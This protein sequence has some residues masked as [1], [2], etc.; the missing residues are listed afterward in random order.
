M[1]RALIGVI[2]GSGLYD[3][4]GL[5]EV[6]EV[7]IDTP[8]GRTSDAI[9][10]GKLAGVPVA[11]LARH[12]RN[13]HLIPSQVPYRANIHA[14]RQLGVRYILSLSAVGSLQEEVRPLDMLIPD[15]FIDMTRRRQSTFFGDG[16]V[17]H[18]SM[19]DPVCPAVADSLARAFT[20]TQAE[21]P[22][23][24]HR[25]GSYICIEGPQFSTRAESHWYRSMGASVIGMTNMPEAKLAREAQ[26]AYATLA[27]ATDYDCWHP[28]EEAVTAEVAIANLQQNATRAQQIA[29]EAIRI[30]GAEQP[31]SSAHTALLS[32]LVT[33]L[34]A[35]PE[36]TQAVIKPLLAPTEP[37]LEEM[38]Q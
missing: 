23:E 37:E 8:F 14:L 35:M 9:V 4:P 32:G 36:E 28:R 1:T 29:M 25:G 34:E 38:E 19:A 13:H 24:L 18:V 11:F 10:C 30:L 21:Q 17:A 15:Q 33:P 5:T 2:G 20:L 16:A 27:M 31:E 12:G 3:M 7:H 26:I 6:E 22:I